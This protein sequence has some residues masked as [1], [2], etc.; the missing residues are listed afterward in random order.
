MVAFT[1]QEQ[2]MYSGWLLIGC[3]ALFIR[4][5]KATTT[6]TT[7]RRML[8]IVAAVGFSA[9]ATWMIAHGQFP[10]PTREGQRR[11]LVPESMRGDWRTL[12]VFFWGIVVCSYVLSAYCVFRCAEGAATDP[13]PDADGSQEA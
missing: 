9:S 7:T 3:I 4:L 12:P 11:D 8:W 1:I 13:R 10:W 5:S 6:I 2:A